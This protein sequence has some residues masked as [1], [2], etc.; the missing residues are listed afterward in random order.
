M[1]A[2]PQKTIFTNDAE[3]VI[4]DESTCVK[5]TTHRPATGASLKS[6]LER[7]A[8]DAE[9]RKLMK[10]MKNQQSE[11]KPSDTDPK[12]VSAHSQKTIIC[13]EEVIVLDET[14]GVSDNTHRPA[15]GASLKMAMER[16]AKDA[17][18]RKLMEEMKN[19]QSEAKPTDT[20]PK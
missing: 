7:L 20:D 9:L 4:L 2:R 18:L 8:K 16:L 10:E 15:T 17:E 14:M 19:Q 13:N 1:S 6:A 3:I 11:A 5:D 12:T